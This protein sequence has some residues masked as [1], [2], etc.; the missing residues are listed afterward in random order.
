MLIPWI[1]NLV[2]AGNVWVPCAFGNVS[3]QDPHIP[4]DFMKN[5]RTRHC[6]KL[7][8]SPPPCVPPNSLCSPCCSQRC[9]QGG[10]L[11]PCQCISL[12]YSSW[13]LGTFLHYFHSLK[14]NEFLC[15]IHQKLRHYLMVSIMPFCQ[16]QVIVFCCNKIYNLQVKASLHVVLTIELWLIFGYLY[17]VVSYSIAP[18]FYGH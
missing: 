6:S 4:Y 12:F 7:F 16:Q 18:I 9:R 13:K 14:V 1:V 17:F 2:K 3:I 8:I 10:W 5:R 15:P 11:T